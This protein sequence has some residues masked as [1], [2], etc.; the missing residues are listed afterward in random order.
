MPRRR[1]PAKREPI[2]DPIY[3]SKLVTRCVNVIMK[4]GKMN[5]PTS[6]IGTAR[7]AMTDLPRLSVNGT[8]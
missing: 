4:Q 5:V 3:R 6:E 7:L 1:V 8:P 2:P